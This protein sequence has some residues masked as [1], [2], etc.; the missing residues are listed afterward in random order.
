METKTLMKSKWVA[1]EASTENIGQSLSVTKK[2]SQSATKSQTNLKWRKKS[3]DEHLRIFMQ[4]KFLLNPN[5][6]LCMSKTGFN[7]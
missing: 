5:L 1:M 7:G 6:N 4:I 3:H 2:N